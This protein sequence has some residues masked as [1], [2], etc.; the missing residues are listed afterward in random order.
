MMPSDLAQPDRL[1]HAKHQ[2]LER[3]VFGSGVPT[4]RQNLLPFL[5]Y[6]R[7]TVPHHPQSASIVQSSHGD[8]VRVDSRLFGVT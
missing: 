3:S 7:A 4:I 8:S 6:F 1:A 5:A 2:V